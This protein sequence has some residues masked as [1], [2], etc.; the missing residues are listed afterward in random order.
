MTFSLTVHLLKKAA[1][2][3]FVYIVFQS[4]ASISM[5]V[6]KLKLLEVPPNELTF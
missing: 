6:L 3:I 5:F 4:A 1:D 2:G